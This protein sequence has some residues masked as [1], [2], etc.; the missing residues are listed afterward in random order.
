MHYISLLVHENFPVVINTI[1]NFLKHT[2]AIIVV[3]ISKSANFSRE[4]LER[5]SRDRFRERVIINKESE[6]TYWGN[7][8]NAMLCNIR[9][10]LKITNQ[11]DVISF[12]ASN[13]L[14]VKD[15]NIEEITSRPNRF[16]QR[17]YKKAGIWSQSKFAFD[18]Q[19]IQKF[20]KQEGLNCIVASQI[21]GSSYCC[22]AMQEIVRIIDKYKLTEGRSFAREEILFSTAANLMRLRPDS[23]PYVFSEL[24][25]IDR[26]MFE[27]EKRFDVFPAPNRFKKLLVAH[28]QKKV[29]DDKKNRIGKGDI[30]A[31][32][33]KTMK[34]APVKDGEL[35]YYPYASCDEIYAVKRVPRLTDDPIRMYISSLK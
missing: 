16:Q 26:K 22:S 21:E 4:I 33:N 28:L 23:N 19:N 20:I 29:W 18:D 2:D 6:E 11:N 3:H 24:H 34:I 14:F 5:Y 7:V 15:L 31:I 9:F 10:I 13:D 30:D 35:L 25:R 12:N 8:Y 32:I 27:I 1:E 17:I